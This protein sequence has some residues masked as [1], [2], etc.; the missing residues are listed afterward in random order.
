MR[1]VTLKVQ[2]DRGDGLT[3]LQLCEGPAI[4]KR[5]IY[6]SFLPILSMGE[7]RSRSL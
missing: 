1:L 3:M 2:T 4:A 6:V 5:N 7:S